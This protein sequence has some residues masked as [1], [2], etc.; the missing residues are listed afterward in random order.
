MDRLRQILHYLA[1]LEWTERKQ[2]DCIFCNR[3]RLRD[4]VYEVCVY[5]YLG[6][7]LP[8]YVDSSSSSG[9]GGIQD[10]FKRDKEGFRLILIMMMMMMILIMTMLRT[11]E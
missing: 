3:E 9:G 5:M 10:I 8:T 7:N 1:H 11:T 6:I 2:H 4:V